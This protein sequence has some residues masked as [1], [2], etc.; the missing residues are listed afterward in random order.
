MSF[1]ITAIILFWL[2]EKIDIVRHNRRIQ[3]IREEQARQ[4]A[5]QARQREEQA[6]ARRER[7]MLEQEQRRQAR[8]QERIDE[9][10][11]R[12]EYELVRL[13]QRLELAEREISHYS[14]VL[15]ALEKQAG[16]LENK[17]WWYE[18][19]GLPCQGIKQELD[20]IKAKAYQVKT[21]IIK[22][23]QTK[24]LCQKKIAA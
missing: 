16:V 1:I 7:A 8:E 18:K 4:R 19:N 5:E 14:P 21:K 6:R 12:H 22:A 10:L 9:A 17:I 3:R 24:A 23:E 13:T 15:E 2:V 20:K 11:K